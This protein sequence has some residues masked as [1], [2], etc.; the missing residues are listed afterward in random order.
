MY[1][2]VQTRA[3]ISAKQLERMLGVTYKTAWRMAKQIRLLMA[4][5]D[6][7]PLKGDVEIDETYFG[8]KGTSRKYKYHK[9]GTSEKECV[10]GMVQRGGKAYLKH[11][12]NSGKWTLLKQIKQYCDLTTRV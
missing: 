12:P 5:I 9:P 1:L 2:M 8:G 7:I 6:L 4:D 11:I 10:M 3:G